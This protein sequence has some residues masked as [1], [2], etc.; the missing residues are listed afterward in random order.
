MPSRAAASA[1]GSFTFPHE[2]AL[3]T[4]LPPQIARERRAQPSSPEM[5]PS[6]VSPGPGGVVVFDSWESGSLA[7]QGHKHGSLQPTSARPAWAT[8]ANTP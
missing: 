4:P 8:L 7:G 5:N 2:P 6:G 1:R 3:A